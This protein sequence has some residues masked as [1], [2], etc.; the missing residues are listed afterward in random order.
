EIRC[1]NVVP[2]EEERAEGLRTVA[3]DKQIDV[4]DMVRLQ[5]D[6]HRGRPFVQSPPH[7]RRVRGRRKWIEQC[8]L[9]A[10]L[11]ARG[12]DQRPPAAA[13]PPVRILHSPEPESRRDVSDLD[14]SHAEIVPQYR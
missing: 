9:A 3:P 10:R 4:A 8:N 1:R 7:I 2:P 12:R 5:C 11:A 6:D 14:W 13:R